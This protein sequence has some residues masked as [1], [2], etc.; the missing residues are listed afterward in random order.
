MHVSSEV[1]AAIRDVP[2]FRDTQYRDLD[3]GAALDYYQRKFVAHC[4]VEEGVIADVGCG[5][6]WL[7]IAFAAGSNLNV[8]AIDLDA[9]RLAAART[10]AGLLGLAN[11]IEFRVGRLGESPLADREVDAVYC[12]EVLEHVD[13]DPRAF[14]DLGRVTKD[15]IVFTTPNGAFPV[16]QHD[17]AL[18]LCHWLPLGLRNIYAKAFGRSDLQ[19]NNLF[20]TPVDIWRRLK[21]FRRVSRFMHYAR[22]SDHL[23]LYPYYLPYGQGSWKRRPSMLMK[24]YV[25]AAD[26]LGRHSYLAM[27]TLS[28]VYRRAEA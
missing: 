3:V 6:G 9:E 28:G 20:W 5:Y 4:P 18:P 17:T 1:Q 19:H 27:H 26:L 24:L 22:A 14:A 16:V 12:I 7:A 2:H 23:A 8:I 21:G 10:I 13:R 25:R 15:Y 11:R